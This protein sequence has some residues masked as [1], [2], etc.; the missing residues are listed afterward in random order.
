MPLKVRI[1]ILFQENIVS[2]L[3][4]FGSYFKIPSKIV[5]IL[6]SSVLRSWSIKPETIQICGN[7]NNIH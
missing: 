1:H 3:Y 2:K 5:V 4:S 7:T 6:I